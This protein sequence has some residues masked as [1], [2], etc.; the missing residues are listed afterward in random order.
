MKLLIYF[1]YGAERAPRGITVAWGLTRPKSGPM[2]G[3]CLLT[4]IKGDRQSQINH[5]AYDSIEADLLKIRDLLLK[6]QSNI[7]NFGTK[8]NSK[9][10][11]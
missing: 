4:H 1:E 3:L 2:H 8:H 7:I 11:Y 10:I 6:L 5:V 9:N